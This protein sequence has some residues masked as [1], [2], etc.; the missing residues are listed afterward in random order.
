MRAPVSARFGRVVDGLPEKG[1]CLRYLF[2]EEPE[3]DNV[4]NCNTASIINTITN[5]IAF[6]Q[7]TEVL[8]SLKGM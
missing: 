4:I 3:G 6:I 5:M 1:I 2:K 7:T 8:K